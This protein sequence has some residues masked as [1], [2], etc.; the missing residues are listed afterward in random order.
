MRGNILGLPFKKEVT[1]Q[2]QTRQEILGEYSNISQEKIL[3]YSSK[4]PWVRLASSINLTDK[5]VPDSETSPP[6]PNA[7]SVLQLLRDSG[8]PE[9]LINNDSLA[10]NL[11][12]QGVL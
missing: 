3:S 6:N 8:V 11:I 5:I 7:K 10:K 4:T 2:I 1:K 12:L 9:G